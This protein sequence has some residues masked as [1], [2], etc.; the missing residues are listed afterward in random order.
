MPSPRETGPVLGVGFDSDGRLIT[1]QA[2]GIWTFRDLDTGRALRTL[3]PRSAPLSGLAISPDGSLVASVGWDNTVWFWDPRSGRA[4]RQLEAQY[5][6]V[7]GVAFD[8]SGRLLASGNADGVI[9]LWATPGGELIRTLEGH[10]GRVTGLAYSPDGTLL[11]SAGSDGDIRIWDTRE[12]RLTVRTLQGHF[13]RVRGIAFSPTAG[14]SPAPAAI[15]PSAS[16]TCKPA[17]SYARWPGIWAADTA[18]R[19]VLMDGCWPARGKT[20]RSGSG[21]LKPAKRQGG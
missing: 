14:G 19:S 12:S 5:A 6:W 21:T 3:D 17:R 11:A 9:K 16:G 20:I 8:P 1:S 10:T 18:W 7:L 2:D 4:L 15:G 13:R